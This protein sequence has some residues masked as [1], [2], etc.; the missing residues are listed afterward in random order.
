MEIHIGASSNLS[1]ILSKNKKSIIK[2]SS[3]KDKNI[4][5]INYNNLSSIKKIIENKNIS[6]YIF[7]L[8]KNFKGRSTKK[9]LYINYKLPL[10]ILNL[11]VKNKKRKIKTIFFG[12]FLENETSTSEN[13]QE[14]KSYKI[15]LRK[16]IIELSKSNKF[17]FVW[18]K[19]PIIYGY[20]LKNK[21][22]L[23][24]LIQK[25]KN[26]E[27]IIIEYKYNTV[28]FL[29]ITE[30]GKII[31]NIKFNWLK[32][33]NKIIVPN[34]EGPYYLFDLMK[35]IKN[36][37][38]KKIQIKYKNKYKRNKIFSKNNINN[39]QVKKDLFKFIKNNV[40]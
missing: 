1:K 33:K 4:L 8:G 16:K 23:N 34:C 36:C 10:K 12:T 20:N 39:F 5:K 21:N 7:F 11:L 13:N 28:Y 18:L 27:K 40:S 22:F 35:K 30:L 9:S 24:I 3:K 37:I 38:N 26:K 14:Y 29:N 19:L 2:I 17:E 15:R 32:Y 31:T 6:Y 25:I